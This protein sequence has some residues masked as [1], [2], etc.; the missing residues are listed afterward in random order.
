MGRRGPAPTPTEILET[1]GS[2]RADIN[3]NPPD[4]KPG[5]P[6]CPSWLDDVS[7]SIWKQLIPL[8]EDM[9]TL[10]ACDVHALSLL[11]RTWSRWRQAE[12]FI[13]E[14]GEV[15][16]I[17][18]SKGKMRELRKFPQVAI[19]SDTARMLNRMLAEFGLTPSARSRIELPTN[20]G[21]QR[22]DDKSEFFTTRGAAGRANVAG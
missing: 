20:P 15:Y 22:G 13:M 11:C 3:R 18:D 6:R 8:L 9:G 21:S 10:Y 17:K 7:K 14:K 16:P 19:A 5:R 12:E 4:A 1:R 2:W